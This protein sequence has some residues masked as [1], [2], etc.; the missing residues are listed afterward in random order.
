MGLPFVGLQQHLR[1]PIRHRPRMALDR[2]SAKA[3][4]APR[5]CAIFHIN[6]DIPAADTPSPTIHRRAVAWAYNQD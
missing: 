1:P 3:R 2:T 6:Q 4:L 5:I